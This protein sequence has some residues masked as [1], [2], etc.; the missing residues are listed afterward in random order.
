MYRSITLWLP[1]VF[2]ASTVLAAPAYSTHSDDAPPIVQVRYGTSD[3]PPGTK[4][5]SHGG[6]KATKYVRHHPG[7]N[8]NRTYDNSGPPPGADGYRRP[9][10]PQGAPYGAPSPDYN[11]D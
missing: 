3:C 10:P 2:T 6:C 4:V 7:Q 11:D 5:T 9:A 8:P 1:V